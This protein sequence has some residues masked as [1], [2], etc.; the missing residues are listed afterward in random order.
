[1][2]AYAL[3][4]LL[5]L[6]G[7]A[8][9]RLVADHLNLKAA[10]TKLPQD[11]EGYYDPERYRRSQIYLRA[12][13]RFGGF[14]AVVDLLI[15]LSVWFG[16]GF[17]FWD[18][19]VGKHQWGAVVSGLV[20]I[21]GLLLVKSVVDLP[22]SVYRTFVIE[23]RFGFNRTSAVTF[24]KDRLK[25]LMLILL[26][27]TPVLGAVLWFFA[28]AGSHAWWLCWLAV[29]CFTLGI[30]FVAPTWIMP[31]FNRF[32]P[33]AEGE[34]KAAIFDYAR[35]IGFPLAKVMVMDGSKRSSK[36]NAF[37]TGFGR[38]RRIV[39]FD[40]LVETHDTKELLAILAH[41]MGH[42]KLHH[43]HKMMTIGVLQMGLMFFVLSRFI[44]EPGLFEAFL[45]PTPSVHAGLVFFSLLFTPL[46]TLLSL[47]GNR[48]SRVHE[49]AADQFA[50]RSMDA[51]PL[52]TALKKLS[53]QNLSN[54]TPHPF[55][56]FLHYSHPPILERLRAIEFRGAQ[57][58]AGFRQ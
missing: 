23:A 28:Q 22:F 2:N 18:A 37:F 4:L 57:A 39:L 41:E 31:L 1:M 55:F 54:L 51:A 12:N 6:S 58:A 38:N 29:S 17:A 35:R 33:L 10:G 3:F 11:F 32:E 7:D 27:G 40:T 36:A 5:A 45:V 42:Y 43:I 8:V 24:V 50:V 34:L 19:W 20:F 48:L 30:Q 47:F 16:G 44:S 13:T 25:S 9:L 15:L 49:Y 53:V 56:V 52:A 21:G 14:V 46:D 26:L